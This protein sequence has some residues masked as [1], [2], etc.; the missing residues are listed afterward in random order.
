M[1]VNAELLRATLAHIEARPED[2]RQRSYRSC[3]TAGCFA[4]H[5]AVLSGGEPRKGPVDNDDDWATVRRVPED[6]DLYASI[7][8]EWMHVADRAQRVLGLTGAQ[9]TRLFDGCNDMVGLRHI[10]A[11]LTAEVPA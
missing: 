6:G 3:G 1:S 4:W 2:W 5:A 9:A 10:V 7:Y 8:G 11:E